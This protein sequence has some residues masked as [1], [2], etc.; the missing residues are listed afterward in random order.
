MK[1]RAPLQRVGLDALHIDDERSLRPVALYARLKQLLLRDG[2]TF[3]VAAPDGPP[4]DWNRALFLNLSFWTPGDGADVL[5]DARIPADVVAHVAWHHLA[6]RALGPEG[7]TTAGLLM[8][9]SIASAFD[10][11]LVGRL[12]LHAPRSAF[13]RTQIPAM[14]EVTQSAGLGAAGFEAM[15]S[16][17]AEDPDAAF[18]ELR[19]L[20]YAAST[21]LARASGA[22]EAAR[23]LARLDGSRFYPLLHHYNLS[24]WV[25][26]T[27][28]YGVEAP[29]AAGAQV[30]RLDR[31]LRRAPV[32]LEWLERNWVDAAEQQAPP[33]PRRSLARQR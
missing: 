1:T 33:A 30:A 6:N 7:L 25:L 16:G 31:A 4:I 10:L 32:A 8:G 27:R 28:A 29:P 12:L 23:V 20:L 14:A 11:Y 22:D 24:N 19:A 18:S 17:I 5:V 3:R 26:Y 2:Y 13:L 15:L 21:R 9:E